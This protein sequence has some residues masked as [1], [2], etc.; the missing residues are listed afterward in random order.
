MRS[1]GLVPIV[2]EQTAKGERSLDIYSRL[3]KERLVFLTGE[4]DDHLADLIV[5]QLLFL[6]SENPEKDVSFYINSPGGSVT[7]GL[8][9]YDVMQ[10]VRP[11]V[12]TYV[13]GQACSMGSFLATA[14]APGKR[15]ILPQARMMIHQPSA[16]TEGKVSDMER[17]MEEYRKGKTNM[18]ELYVHHN[19][20]SIEFKEMTVL[21]DRDT[22]FSAKETVDLGFA[23]HVVDGHRPLY[24]HKPPAK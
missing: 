5:A 17:D 14:G 23:D 4:V 18:T 13:I 2:I 20:A 9:I 8:A 12:A 21:L 3:L 22:Y 24:E 1:Q 10:Y 15:F 7:A 11:D 6:E 19:S 16:G